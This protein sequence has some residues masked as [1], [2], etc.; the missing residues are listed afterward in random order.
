MKRLH[1][2]MLL[3]TVT[4]S[5]M[6]QT[7]GEA[8][9]IYRNDGQINGFL[10]G[11]IQSMEYSRTDADGNQYDEIVT[12]IVN[13]ADSIYQIPLAEIDSISFVT[14]KTEY[15]PGVINLSD[16][17]MPYVVSSNELTITFSSTM[18]SDLM[19][20]VG[21]K[22]V[23][24]EMNEKFP[25]GFAGEVISVSGSQVTCKLVCLEEV[26]KTYYGVSST[27]GY[28]EGDDAR[29]FDSRRAI[30]AYGNK[31]F[32]LG[33]FS[34][35]MGSELSVN[36]F[37]SDKLAL[38]GGTQTS[39]GITPSFHI[40]STLIIN[41]E[42][43]TYLNACINS[44]MT[45]EEK[46]SIYGGIEW[47]YEPPFNKEWIKAPIAPLTFFYVKPGLFLRASATISATAVF[48]Q[49]Y[50]I[51]AAFDFSTKKRSVIKP[52]CG[53]RLVS[54]TYDMEGAIDGSLAV[55]GFVE[56]G[57][58]FISSDIDK[59]CSRGE[60]GLELVGHAMLY[61]S[62]IEEAAK[63]TKVY[64]RFKNSSIE[65]N[66]FATTSLQAELGPW[67]TSFSLPWNLSYNIKTWD[68][69]PSFSDTSLRQKLNP[70]TSADAS[71]KISGDCF[72]P[73]LAGLSLRD[74]DGR[75]VGSYYPSVSFF[76]GNKSLETTFTGLVSNGNY[77]LYPKVRILGYEMLA[78]PD[79]DL[80]QFEFT[81]TTDDTDNLTENSVTLHAHLNAIGQGMPGEVCFYYGT[82]SNPQLSGTIVNVGSAR[83]LTSTDF[84]ANVTNLQSGTT[85]Y[86]V[87]AYNNGN[88]TIY[89]EVRSFETKR[90]ASVVTGEATNVTSN[91]AT[92]N[93]YYEGEPLHD[94]YGF[95]YGTSS[96]ISYGN[97]NTIVA[98]NMYNGHFSATLSGLSEETTYYYR[99]YVKTDV[100]VYGELMT[101]NTGNSPQPGGTVICP[102]GNHPHW[103]DMGLPS[104]TKWCCCN[105]GAST[106]EA[107]GNYY[108]FAQVNSAPSFDQ[109]NELLNKCTYTWTTLNGVNGGKFTGPN[110]AAIFLPAAGEKLDYR[111]WDV[112]DF[113][114]Y[115][116][117]TP[118]EAQWAYILSF[119]SDGAA[120]EYRSRTTEP[121]YS[122][123]HIRPVRK[124]Y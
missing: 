59:L 122:E 64:E 114:F 71:V 31:D 115:W 91:G 61:N 99:A 83:N 103:I 65:L 37:G 35:S 15:Q 85:Y 90:E 111:I 96:D 46:V 69:V 39:I 25:A 81:V 123:L 92:L 105:E 67:G 73:V 21:D 11:E 13:T 3:A 107:F 34:W 32:K 110:G 5:G 104:G 44:D 57:L 82:D 26:F 72:F 28:Q 40:M 49:R 14:P 120:Y 98:I 4:L 113:G 50:A 8:M 124:N 48:T 17:L 60:L 20:Q 112:G 74:K 27:Y 22:L 16:Q 53:G 119:Y 102:D 70:M 33:T 43:G 76:N 42:D 9:Y 38:K 89:G 58:T 75:E 100:I 19:P 116:S 80:E 78:S 10:P 23:T 54:S 24:L 79:S 41:D 30:D 45:V 51:G 62:D 52:A 97:G 118:Y 2:I 108:S 95:I 18:P 66:A 84:S 93:G 6:A 94:D 56:V 101:F 68:V 87:A 86:Y 88:N 63:E 117:S 55:G 121:Q 47:T 36:I 1:L 109:I 12:Q 77:K 106:P 29:L 7:I